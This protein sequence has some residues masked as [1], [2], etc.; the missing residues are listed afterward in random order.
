MTF[1]KQITISSYMLL[2]RHPIGS[3]S[4]AIG[5]LSKPSKMPWFSYSI[6]AQ[7]CRIGS[8]LRKKVG[9]TC[10]KCY[11]LKGRYVFE[12]VI[13]ALE[14][15]YQLLISS[16]EAWA[17]CFAGLLEKKAKGLEQWFRWHD[18]GDLQGLWHLEAI[19]WIAERLPNIHFWLPTR[20]L[21][22][23]KE[24][25]DKHGDFPANLMVR[26]S[27]SSINGT[28]FLSQRLKDAGVTTSSVG[29]VL[30]IETDSVVCPANRNEGKCGSCR[31]CW[32]SKLNV[33]YPLH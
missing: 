2:L 9:S 28:P 32:K 14:H 6:P 4:K 13:K 24:Y 5:G 11:A 30:K 7:R 16:P 20:E 27:A 23:V 26:W 18:A 22:T 31:A 17:A 21:P 10:S 19:V 25:V 1:N 33:N 8:I 15:R 3:L 12:N 29:D